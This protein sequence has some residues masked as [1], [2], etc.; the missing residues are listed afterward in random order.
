VPLRL[1]IRRP[2]H[3]PALKHLLALVLLLPVLLPVAAA[4]AAS[5]ERLDHLL[6]ALADAHGASIVYSS[7][8]VRS[9]MRVSLIPTGDLEADLTAALAPHGLRVTQVEDVYVV[10]ERNSDPSSGTI[11]GRVID[12]GDRRPLAG[13]RVSVSGTDLG[14]VTRRSGIYRLDG[15]APGDQILVADLRGFEPARAPAI[16]VAPGA[17]AY[18]VI[19]LDTSDFDL[20]AMV[21]TTSRVRLDRTPLTAESRMDHATLIETPR[22]G[23]EVLRGVHDIP[24]FVLDGVSARSHVRGGVSDET[25]VLFDGIRLYEPYHL[26]DFLAPFSVFDPLRVE[27]ITVH[28]G[29][30]SPRFG[31]RMSGVLEVEPTRSMLVTTGAVDVSL[32]ATAGIISGG[33]A[34]GRGEWLASVRESNLATLTNAFETEIGRPQFTD[35]YLTTGYE[36]PSG[37]QLTGSLLIARDAIN[38]TRSA[39]TET[40]S[41]DYRDRYLWLRVTWPLADGAELATTLTSV[42]LEGGRS[43]S[44]LRLGETQGSLTDRWD[45][46]ILTLSADLEWWLSERTRL[47]TGLNFDQREAQFEFQSTRVSLGPL[48]DIQGALSPGTRDHSLA[49]DGEAWGG[50]LELRHQLRQDLFIEGGLRV[51][52]SGYP[53][54][55]YTQLSPR[56]SLAWNPDQSSTLRASTGIYRQAQQ[57][58]E[59]AIGDGETDYFAPERSEQWVVGYDRALSA[60]L[61][62]RTEVY[63]KRVS[64]PWTRYENLFDSRTLVP[65]IEPDRVRLSP[66]SATADGVETT[67][68]WHD[69]AREIT[70]WGTLTFARAEDRIAGVSQSRNWERRYAMDLGL[71][72]PIGSWDLQVI[73]RLAQGVPSTGLTLVPQGGAAPPLAVA[74]PRN[75]QRLERGLTIDVRVA[76][77]W[78]HRDGEMEVYFDIANITDVG[79]ACCTKYEISGAP[80][81]EVLERE[82]EDWFGLVPNVGFRWDF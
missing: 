71:R 35:A 49:T 57:L 42:E 78:A 23:G 18:A 34:G 62:L 32:F 72:R 26:K 38:L 2:A 37:V 53:G 76:R 7:E 16:S 58:Q 48:G 14:T 64:N 79:T 11:V 70:Y 51:D 9:D 65:E 36:F 29:G 61:W 4:A 6:D 20:G 77:S 41:S 28:A 43:G 19:E 60:R 45:T 56:L 67:L 40:A 74:G 69:V 66:S 73:G 12:V 10:R 80:G 21:V 1:K 15:V 13:V 47:R 50:Y 63:S 27:A 54:V 75:A 33:Y 55:S 3:A 46:N 30:F 81:S 22:I 59:L 68:V 8:T 24:G 44:Q 17:V 31:D 39:A 82:E 52:H 5:A 25:L